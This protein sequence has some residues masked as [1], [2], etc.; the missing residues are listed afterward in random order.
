MWGI[1]VIVPNKLQ[2]RV[3]EE[4]NTG[5][6]EI[7]RMKTLARSPIWWPYMEQQKRW[8]GNM[9]LLRI[10]QHQQLSIHGLGQQ[11][12][13]NACILTSPA[14]FL[15]SHS[16]SLEMAQGESYDENHC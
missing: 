15:V 11:I 5:H 4:L 12:H 7:I 16:Y 3:L 6:T 13:G 1:K 2:G 8:Y 14:H 10:C 9:S